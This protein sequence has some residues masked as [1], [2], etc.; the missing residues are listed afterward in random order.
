MLN[1]KNSNVSLLYLNGIYSINDN[2]SSLLWINIIIHQATVTVVIAGGNQFKMSLIGQFCR[3][4]ERI[5]FIQIL[6]E[7]NNLIT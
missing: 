5:F 4:I 7:Y 2:L 6:Y 1:R 3:S